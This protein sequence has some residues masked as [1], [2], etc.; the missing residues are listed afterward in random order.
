MC[1]ATLAVTLEKGEKLY[2]N[3]IPPV[4]VQFGI[5]N[6]H[7]KIGIMRTQREYLLEILS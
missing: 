6:L 2:Q 3:V 5:A 4:A 7:R 1:D